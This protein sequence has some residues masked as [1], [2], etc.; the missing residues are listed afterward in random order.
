MAE[1][2]HQRAHRPTVG[3][4]VNAQDRGLAFHHR[5][6]PTQARSNVVLPA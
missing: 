4:Q 6:R 5:N 3:R 2:A 1:Q